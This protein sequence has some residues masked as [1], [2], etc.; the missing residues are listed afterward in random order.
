MTT[1]A[2]PVPADRWCRAGVL[3]P[4]GRVDLALPAD[5]PVAELVPMVLELIGEPSRPDGRGAAPVPQPWRLCGPAGGPLPPEATLDGLGV[6]D[7]ELLHLGPRASSVPAPVFDDSADALAAAVRDG[8][9]AGPWRAGPV[10]APAVVTAAAALLATVRESSV[11]LVVAAAVVAVVGAGVALLHARRETLDSTSAGSAALCAIGPA[12][13]AG[14]LMLPGPL[15]AGQLLLGAIGAG[16]AATLGLAVLRRVAPAL[17]GR[18]RRRPALVVAAVVRL[19]TAAPV[20][21]VAAGLAAV[22]LAAGPV[23]PRVALRIA[24]MPAPVV[25]TDLEEIAR[26]DTAVLPAPELARRADLARGLFAAV[27]AGAA[28]LAGGGA[29]VAA[30]DGGWAGAT[31]AAVTVAVLLLRARAF[32]EDVPA[33]VLTAAAVGTALGAGVLTA[34]HHG[35][36]VRLLTAAGLALGRARGG[37]RRAET[38]CPRSAGGRW[39]CWSWC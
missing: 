28:L 21:A 35:P 19:G 1:T 25:P 9:S 15:G 17:L 36:V 33:Q 24:G 23:L 20:G 22:A 26:A 10:A 7:G 32:A 3:T 37:P 38:R 5:V 18:G 39:T 11:P 13:A 34:L 14:V 16:L 4:R 27:S 6:L 2:H 29:V 8:G 12:A 31:L 30:A